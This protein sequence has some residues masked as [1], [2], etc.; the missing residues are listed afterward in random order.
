MHDLSSSST[1]PCPVDQDE[2][3]KDRFEAQHLRNYLMN[4]FG[5]PLEDRKH[6]LSCESA[7]WLQEA[8]PS[9]GLAEIPY[10]KERAFVDG[11]LMFGES[12]R[13]ASEVLAQIRFQTNIRPSS[14]ERR[15]S[16]IVG[17]MDL[18]A[19][20]AAILKLMVRA[21]LF[22]PIHRLAASIA[23]MLR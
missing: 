15:L 11:K 22:L 8:E 10:D 20:D 19:P 17:I 6:R 18:S 1:W 12:R 23:D 5:L 14:L 21:A 9:I 13:L 16:W 4:A 7:Q 3:P 2:F